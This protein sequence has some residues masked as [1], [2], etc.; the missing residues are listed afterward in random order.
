MNPTHQDDPTVNMSIDQ[1]VQPN[2]QTVPATFDISQPVVPGHDMVVNHLDGV[3]ELAT[4][5]EAV[6]VAAAEAEQGQHVP[7]SAVQPQPEETVHRSTPD[8]ETNQPNPAVPA[9]PAVV[10]PVETPEAPV[11]PPET[12]VEASEPNPK[13]EDTAPSEV[14]SET[15]SEPSSDE[16]TE[17]SSE[18]V[19]GV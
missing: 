4:G 18:D 10:N 2:T 1:K 16:T 7:V 6:A 11:E 9:V 13:E 12:P 5:N 3:Q 15:P 19:A 14:P 17:P 8:P